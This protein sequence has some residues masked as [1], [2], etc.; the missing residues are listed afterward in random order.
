M[1]K[2][3]VEKIAKSLPKTL[4]N[5]TSYFKENFDK[6]GQA[7]L[8]NTTGT[9]GILIEFFAQDKIDAYFKKI[10]EKK[11]ENF[12]SNVYL[13][14]SLIQ[15]GKSIESL[16]NEAIQI[17]DS[18]FLLELFI[19]MLGET[20]FNPND[21]LTI[22]TP[23]YHPIVLFVKEQ[24]EKM[25]DV[26]E[27]HPQVIQSFTRDF[28]KNIEATLKETFGDEDY[29]RHI[30]E[31]KEFV[32]EESESKLLHDMYELRKIGFK[33]GESLRYEEAYASWKP[34]SDVLGKEETKKITKQ[35][36][37]EEQKEH[38]EL[39]A[40]LRP[41]Q[42]L[43]EEYFETYKESVQNIL[44]VIADFG[45]GKTVFLKQYASRL[46]KE[47]AQTKEGYFPIYFNL[48][49]F[50]NYSSD[51]TLGVLGHFLL[52]EYGIRID[53]EEFK[54]KKYLFLVD[55]LDESGE[56]TQGKID[57]VV[58]SIK[59]IQNI[60]K[61]TR[62]DNR[63]V[64]SSRPFSEALERQLKAHKPLTKLDKNSNEIPQY[65]S[66]Y[67]FKEEQFNSWLSHTLASEASAQCQ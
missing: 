63:I 66:L 11:L 53:D 49:N 61:E 37:E 15:V 62:R 56:L 25:L 34:V 38:Q 8:G 20:S 67:G 43:I 24:M 14:A 10:T 65:I 32:L 6:S 28:N 47:Y 31:I 4:K 40:N 58:E 18:S 9:V 44:F 23:Q 16:N 50:S 33:D 64:I 1:K 13:Q 51:G 17:E 7:L 26:L 5:T 41:T 19:D 54:K 52:D 59:N 35:N 22:F 2:K 39:E 46:A 48:R 21:I 12:A 55:S 45:K 29:A 42:E 3:T 27:L 36:K 30:E 57:R 60:D